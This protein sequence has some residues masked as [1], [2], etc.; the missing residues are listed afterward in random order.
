MKKEIKGIK[1]AISKYIEKHDGDAQVVASVLA[2]EG[3]DFDIVDDAIFAFG[4]KGGL[5]ID[6]EALVE[7]VEKEQEEFIMW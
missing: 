5:L 7:E 1:D 3:E 4:L 2:F 6:L